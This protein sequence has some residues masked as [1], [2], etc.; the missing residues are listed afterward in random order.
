[1]ALF[2]ESFRDE[3]RRL[4]RKEARALTRATKKAATQHRREIATLK[5]QIHALSKRL[6]AVE[7]AER[8]R[9]CRHCRQRASKA[10]DSHRAGSNRIG[11]ASSSTPKATESLSVF[12]LNPSTYGREAP[13]RGPR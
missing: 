2:I 10:L 9:H 8:M 1:M 12:L 3:V 11:S 7:G 6:A 13:A 4:A 5:R